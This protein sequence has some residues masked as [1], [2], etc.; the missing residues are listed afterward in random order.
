[1]LWFVVVGR[2]WFCVVVA[3]V[4]VVF[5]FVVASLWSMV[6]VVVFNVVGKYVLVLRGPFDAWL[7][8]HGCRGCV[9]FGVPELERHVFEDWSKLAVTVF[10]ADGAAPA[11]HHL[12][13]VRSGRR[14]PAG[15]QRR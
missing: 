2:P 4:V 1:M 3:V 14:A 10:A 13:H 9:L 12:V 7:C 5:V 15:H 8:G 11:D 6:L